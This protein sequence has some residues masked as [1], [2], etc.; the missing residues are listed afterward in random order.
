MG[1]V[2]TVACGV[3]EMREER[4][5]LLGL[6]FFHGLFIPLLVVLTTATAGGNFSFD[7][8]LPIAAWILGG[9]ALGSLLTAFQNHPRRKLGLVSFGS[10]GLAA[11]LVLFA[12]CVVPSPCMNLFL[13]CMCGLLGSP[14]AETFQA[15]L[16]VEE[17]G[18]GIASC[19][20]SKATPHALFA[21]F[22]V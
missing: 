20:I 3:G 19:N 7:E 11:G 2:W 18:P 8:V 15:N 22:S 10:T 14:L 17:R 12:L 9:L 5:C 16:P 4:Q 13:G 21:E 1:V 6:A